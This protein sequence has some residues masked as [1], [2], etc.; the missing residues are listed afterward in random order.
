V[1]IQSA[2]EISLIESLRS[3]PEQQLILADWYDDRGGENDDERAR[4]LRHPNIRLL[5]KPRFEDGLKR[6]LEI[7]PSCL[8][9]F[10][11]TD[12]R[13]FIEEH[14]TIARVWGVLDVHLTGVH[15]SPV[16]G[17][18]RQQRYYYCYD[19]TLDDT[20]SWWIH[21]HIFQI[22]KHFDESTSE[23]SGY[24][25]D[26]FDG[27]TMTRAIQSLRWACRCLLADVINEKR[28]PEPAFFQVRR[29]AT[30]TPLPS[31]ERPTSVSAPLP[32]PQNSDDDH[33]DSDDDWDY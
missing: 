8:I 33:D 7:Y 30:D 13:T 6:V 19:K 32:I 21:S 16:P 3:C 20:S 9:N 5:D 2:A 15:P 26:F 17:S 23:D 11:E 31:D 10:I 18:Y 14:Q 28:P 29:M 12:Q 1:K 27:D 22:F 4:L 24:F 25:I